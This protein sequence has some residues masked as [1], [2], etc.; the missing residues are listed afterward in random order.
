MQ[1]FIVGSGMR[2]E[3]EHHKLR[4]V[5]PTGETVCE[6][7]FITADSIGPLRTAVLA[8]QEATD[9]HSDDEHPYWQGEAS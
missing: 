8:C 3:V 7:M 4:M 1:S 2:Y 5:A 9:A 6:F